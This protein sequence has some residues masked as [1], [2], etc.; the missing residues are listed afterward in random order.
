MSY[1][2]EETAR[3]LRLSPSTLLFWEEAFQNELNISRD[4]QGALCFEEHHLRALGE[5]RQWILLERRPLHDVRQ[6]LASFLFALRESNNG[7]APAKHRQEGSEI[8]MDRDKDRDEDRD[9]DREKHRPRDHKDHKNDREE[10]VRSLPAPAGIEE[11]QSCVEELTEKVNYLL[12][13]NRALQ[14]LIGRLIEFI[15]RLSVPQAK[16]GAASSGPALDN[17]TE[18]GNGRVSVH[19]SGSTNGQPDAGTSALGPL[20]TAAAANTAANLHEHASPAPS[21]PRRPKLT[22]AERRAQIIAER[23]ALRA[24]LQG[25]GSDWRANGAGNGVDELPGESSWVEQPSSGVVKTSG[26]VGTRS[27]AVGATSG[28]HD[29]TPVIADATAGTVGLTSVTADTTPATK[30][31]GN[32]TPR[33]WRPKKVDAET[34]VVVNRSRRFELAEYRP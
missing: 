3:L 27:G 10:A 25:N 23:E 15:E 29:T 33:P 2:L 31:P 26:L 22:L 16:N 24:Q 14:E 8:E 17:T 5:L 28:T 19:L 13:E 7:A 32:K 12:E 18:M 11:L 30:T 9:R 21:A 34:V 4:A 6:R 1:T 20:A